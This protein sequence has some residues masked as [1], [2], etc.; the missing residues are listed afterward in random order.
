[1]EI[2]AIW[3]RMES[4]KACVL[5]E[6]DGTWRRVVAETLDGPFSHITELN[7]TGNGPKAGDPRNVE[8][9]EAAE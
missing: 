9:F 6:K 7:I 3:L 4:G 5:F 1:M 8:D 2:S